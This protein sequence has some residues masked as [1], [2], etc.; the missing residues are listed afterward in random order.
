M[1]SLVIDQSPISAWSVRN[2][3]NSSKL[4]LAK[5]F[6]SIMSSQIVKYIIPSFSVSATS[7]LFS[8]LIAFTELSRFRIGIQAISAIVMHP[9]RMAADAYFAILGVKVRQIASNRVPWPITGHAFLGL[10]WFHLREKQL[11]HFFGSTVRIS[12]RYPHFWQTRVGKPFRKICSCVML[13]FYPI[14]I[15]MSRHFST[16][17]S[18]AS[19]NQFLE[20][21]SN[22]IRLKKPLIHAAI[23]FRKIGRLD[24]TALA[25]CR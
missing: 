18:P 6:M 10:G 21:P 20:H 23:A 19:V 8:E 2:G 12:H 9:E 13:P 25:S 15:M 17:L 24:S 1:V 16:Y 14:T 5:V 22:P 11:G 3:H 4:A 7:I